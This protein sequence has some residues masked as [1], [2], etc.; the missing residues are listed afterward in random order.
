M[1][2]TKVTWVKTKN[3]L[4]VFFVLWTIVGVRVI[5]KVVLFSLFYFSC[6]KQIILYGK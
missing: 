3:N 4:F 2:R 6:E 5:D 1:S